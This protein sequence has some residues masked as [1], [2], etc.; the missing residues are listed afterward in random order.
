MEFVAHFV[1]KE[2]APGCIYETQLSNAL[3]PSITVVEVAQFAFKMCSS[4]NCVVKTM[5]HKQNPSDSEADL[6]SIIERVNEAERNGD[7]G[8]WEYDK[9]LQVL[10]PESQKPAGNRVMQ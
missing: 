9:G 10:L 5:Q 8:P 6:L 2:P 7:I 3:L 4:Q 1:H